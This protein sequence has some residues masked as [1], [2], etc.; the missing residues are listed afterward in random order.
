MGVTMTGALRRFGRCRRDG[1]GDAA[2]V[3]PGETGHGIRSLIE[4]ARSRLKTAINSGLVL[5]YWQIGTRR[6]IGAP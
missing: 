6:G 1:I 2:C 5:L 4:I 3:A